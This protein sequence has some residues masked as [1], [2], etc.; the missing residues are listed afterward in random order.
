MAVLLVSLLISHTASAHAR[1]HLITIGSTG[2]TVKAGSS[3]KFRVSGEKG[4][5]KI[6]AS[7]GTVARVSPRLDS[8]YWIYHAPTNVL[9]N[10][11]VNLVISNRARLFRL[12]KIKIIPAGLG[13]TGS[14]A[15]PIPTVINTVITP[16]ATTTPSPTHIVRPDLPFFTSTTAI[17]NMQASYAGSIVSGYTLTAHPGSNDWPGISITLGNDKNGNPVYQGAPPGYDAVKVTVLNQSTE[18]VVLNF[19]ARD[20]S[21]LSGAPP[22]GGSFQIS[23]N[24]PTII[25]LPLVA[26]NCGVFLQAPNCPPVLPYEN[27]ESLSGTIDPKKLTSLGFTFYKPKQDITVTVSNIEF[28]ATGYEAKIQSPL[29]D[30]YGQ[31]V[32]QNDAELITSNNQLTSN[33]QSELS[34][35]PVAAKY[36]RWGG[37]ASGPHLSKSSRFTVQ[38]YN[39]RWTLVT[40]DGSLYFGMGFSG[41]YQGKAEAQSETLL[42]SREQ[43]FTAVPDKIKFAAA[44][45]KDSQQRDI[46]D[47]RLADLIQ[48]G[49]SSA[50]VAQTWNNLFAA[51]MSYLGLNSATYWPNDGLI[52]TVKIP[53]LADIRPQG[54]IV[55]YRNSINFENYDP[56]DPNFIPGITSWMTGYWGPWVKS[57]PYLIGVYSQI[58]AS[59][60]S[61]NDPY[62]LVKYILSQPTVTPAGAVFTARLRSQGHSVSDLVTNCSATATDFASPIVIPSTVPDACNA[63]LSD[64][65]SLYADK[66][67][68][69]Y[70]SVLN[71]VAP[72]V[73][74]V[75]DKFSRGSG[76]PSEV[77]SAAAKNCDIISVDLYTPEVTADNLAQFNG[78]DKP[79][80]ITE[81]HQCL[82]NHGSWAGTWQTASG[83]D[84]AAQASMWKRYVQSAWVDTRIVGIDYYGLLAPTPVLSDQ[85][86]ETDECSFYT[87][88]NVPLKPIIQAQQSLASSMYATLWP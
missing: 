3:Q 77:V 57:D 53:Y 19:F 67:Y 6:H 71:G 73:L 50:N 85:W 44:Y 27:Q 74:Y 22:M 30:I 61:D 16:T 60:Y 59:W 64:L 88:A 35:V 23:P 7:L 45:G 56:W 28:I 14:G 55:T 36:D 83:T 82:L 2:F 87:N 81:T 33:L 48:A 76:M 63:I 26:E 54:N 86:N 11:I 29:V 66:Y 32:S 47:F 39:G 69:T 40:P 17:S 84:E 25:S 51:R 72:G 8:P 46:F 65:L 41:G 38:K 9:K 68:S 13:S 21:H 34:Q 42:Q 62:W 5:L 79:I 80:F 75:C 18:S 12:I 52:N 58:E 4:T 49:I 10:R 78:V 37:Y 20:L 70:K 24:I 31:S 1:D 15:F 43:L